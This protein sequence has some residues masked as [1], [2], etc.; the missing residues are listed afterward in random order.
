[1][2]PT[3]LLWLAETAYGLREGRLFF[4]ERFGDVGMHGHVCYCG[5]EWTHSDLNAGDPEAHT[6]PE[7]GDGPIWE[8]V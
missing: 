7:C 1:M 3:L 6:C 4:A 5:A 2:T 8:R